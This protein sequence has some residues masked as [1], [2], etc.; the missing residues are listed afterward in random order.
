M[1]ERGQEVR[2]AWKDWPKARDY[3][4]WALSGCELLKGWAGLSSLRGLVHSTL[5]KK[6]VCVHVD[7]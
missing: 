5:N 7:V 6:L 2:G 4:L 1:A 3:P